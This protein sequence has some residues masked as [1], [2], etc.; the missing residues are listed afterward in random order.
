[1]YVVVVSII[2]LTLIFLITN[3]NLS[4]I[5]L[6]YLLLYHYL[7]SLSPFISLTLIFFYITISYHYLL[8]SSNLL[9]YHYL[10]SS[11]ITISYLLLSLSLIFFDITISY[12]LSSRPMQ[13]SFLIYISL[14]FYNKLKTLQIKKI[15]IF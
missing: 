2:T 15:M 6:S 12:L 11:F 1:M 8:S 13:M 7:L 3:S 4:F 14:S 5:S 9:L 10:L